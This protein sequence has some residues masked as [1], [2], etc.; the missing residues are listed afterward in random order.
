LTPHVEGTLFR[1]M[2]ECLSNVRRH[3]GSPS[4]AVRIQRNDSEIVLEVSDQGKGIPH[5]ILEGGGEPTSHV[6]LGIAGM[7]ERLQ[8][9][10]GRLEVL[11]ANPGTTVRA[12]LPL[13][14]PEARGPAML[15]KTSGKSPNRRAL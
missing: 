15:K 4:A 5:R 8:E 14:N 6:G 9:I 12:I 3:S 1:V 10:G 11:S 7:R 13:A 2:Q